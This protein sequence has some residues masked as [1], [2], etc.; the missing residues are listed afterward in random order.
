MSVDQLGLTVASPCAADWDSMK[1]SEQV[2]FCTHCE[3]SIHNLSEMTRRDAL[4]LARSSGGN[5]CVRYYRRPDGRIASAADSKLHKIT[6]RASRIAAGAFGAAVTFGASVAAHAQPGNDGAQQTVEVRR[7]AAPAPEQEAA[8]EAQD[9]AKPNAEGQGEEAKPETFALGGVMIMVEPK[10]PLVRAAFTDDLPAAKN[11]IALGADVNV[12]D[13]EARTT[14]LIQAALHGNA[15]LV[16]AL[17][18]AG[19]D[20]NMKDADGDTAL[21]SLNEGATVELVRALLWAGA[22]VNHRN[23]Y[24]VTPLINAAEYD[25]PKVFKALIEAGAKVNAKNKEGTTALMQAAMYGRLDNVKLLL[26]AGAD[27]NAKDAEGKTALKLLREMEADSSDE[28]DGT[29]A[30]EEPEDPK[31]SE[32]SEESEA[33]EESEESEE[34]EEPDVTQQIITLLVSYGAIE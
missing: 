34:S 14:A 11:L 23:D 18:S 15:E 29:E 27:V 28:S 22:K 9:D 25:N 13:L 12:L 26:E 20:V 31:A 6:R 1:G 10:D 3:K 30:S 8:Q 7:A 19:A 32:A 4:R 2:R 33:P 17:L 21:T 24:G 5:L 16:S